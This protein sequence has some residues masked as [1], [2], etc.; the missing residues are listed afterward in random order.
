MQQ[1]PT[2][3]S[4][5]GKMSS[6]K[7]CPEEAKLT[8]L[9]RRCYYRE[10]EKKPSR[11]TWKKAYGSSE[12]RKEY[13]RSYSKTEAFARSQQ[14]YHRTEKFKLVINRYQTTINA[15]YKELLRTAKRRQLEVNITFE[16]YAPLV[17]ENNCFYCPNSLSKL[18]SGLDRKDNSIGYTL[19]NVVPCCRSCNR[20][21]GD[22]L[23][24][25]EMVAISDLLNTMR[26]T[27]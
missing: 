12:S 5:E 18:G 8:G 24:F 16:Q 21:K 7:I 2:L 22:R 13:A 20:T 6:C 4:W 19:E 23:T 9:C 1:K 10:Y 26:K 11:H 14:K 17:Q 15:K 3:F 27:A 25:E